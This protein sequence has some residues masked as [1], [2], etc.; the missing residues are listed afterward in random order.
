MKTSATI[1]KWLLHQKTIVDSWVLTE[2]NKRK[3]RQQ[4]YLQVYCCRNYVAQS[5]SY[6]LAMQINMYA[7]KNTTISLFNLS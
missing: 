1:L 7:F 6:S 2:Q 3:K 5:T 4:Q